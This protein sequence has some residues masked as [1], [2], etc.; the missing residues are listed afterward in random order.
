LGLKHRIDVGNSALAR[1]LCVVNGI[2]VDNYK[3]PYFYR[4]IDKAPYVKNDKNLLVDLE[5]IKLH[6]QERNLPT[7]D[8]E[9]V[10]IEIV[11]R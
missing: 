1:F 8:I 3:N 2:D 4:L 5:V 10:I 6:F 11:T 7:G 9:K